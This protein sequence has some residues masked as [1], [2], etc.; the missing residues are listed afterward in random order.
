VPPFVG[1]DDPP[2][3][4]SVRSEGGCYQVGLT[5]RGGFVRQDLASPVSDALLPTFEMKKVPGHTPSIQRGPQRSDD[6]RF[7]WSHRV[8]QWRSMG[9][10]LSERVVHL[11]PVCCIGRGRPQPRH[12]GWGLRRFGPPNHTDGRS[13]TSSNKWGLRKRSGLRQMAAPRGPIGA[14]VQAPRGAGITTRKVRAVATQACDS[15]RLR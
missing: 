10:R 2:Y 4:P 8:S 1:H 3:L 15:I 5:Q 14:V 9:P 11:S 12:F 13:T 7:D 6:R